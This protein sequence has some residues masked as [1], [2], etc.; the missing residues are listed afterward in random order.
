MDY[1]VIVIGGGVGGLA[2]A[3]KLSASGKRVLVLEKQPIPGGIATSF[4][5]KGFSFEAALHI[6][7]ALGPDGEIRKFLD[8]YGVSQKI[9]YL[10][11]KEFGQVIYPEYNFIVKNDFESL[12]N[13]L[14][15][16]FPQEKIGI[17][18]F[19][20]EINKFYK[21][22]DH[23]TNSRVPLWLK[24]LISPLIYPNIIKTSCINL[25][26]FITKKIKDKKLR[27][28][29]GTIWGFIGLPPSEISAFYFLIILRGYWGEKT[30]FIKGG[31]SKLFNAMAD[32]IKEYGSE[33][34]FNTIVT[35]IITEDGKCIKAVRTNK[36]EEFRTKAIISNANAIDTL[37]KFIDCDVL[38]QEYLKKLSSMQ[39][40]LSAVIVYLGLNVPAKALGI[41]YPLISL[42][43]DYDHD[44]AY[45][46]AVSSNYKDCNLAII[47]H[48]QLDPGLVP[49][50]KSTICIMSL[51]NYADWDNLTE[52]EYQ[53][54]KKEVG[55]SIVASLEK[56]FS[57]LSSHI[58]VI[59]VGT[60]KTIERYAAIPNGAIYGFDETVGQSSINRLPQKTKIKGLFLTGAWTTP[61]CGVHG[62][63]VS[64]VDAAEL[65]LNFLNEDTTYGIK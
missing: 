10:D 39:K 12:Q 1:D 8:E 6:V 47:D 43:L 59:E 45:Q 42:N 53:K 26:Q 48:S 56:Y 9:E 37:T 40:S 11:F 38:K 50:G 24:L 29:I 21:E 2:S 60:P 36:G 41:N 4:K 61:G 15:D 62:C 32:R 57:G 23:F 7:D 17:D 20:K 27:S 3:L 14:I 54:K 22:L 28:I 49:S 35:Q 64:G 55:D 58:E 52:E 30:S 13:W 25:E 51:A 19:F 18:V 44:K 63:F 65:A 34:R 5:K 31:F 16:N 46:N 33:V